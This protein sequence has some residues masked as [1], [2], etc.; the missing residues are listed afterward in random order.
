MTP[1]PE[2]T[3]PAGGAAVSWHRLGAAHIVDVFAYVIVLGLFTQFF[4]SVITETF[5]LTLL[6]A[7]LLKV[8]LEL[9]VSVKKPIAKRFRAAEHPLVKAALGLALFVVLA[10]SKFVVLEL[11]D[12]VFGDAVRLGGFIEVTLLIFALMAARAGL[13]RLIV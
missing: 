13:R 3:D 4:P 12:L 11:T 8:V 10:G 6:T 1:A 2:K 9:V 5:T 7:L